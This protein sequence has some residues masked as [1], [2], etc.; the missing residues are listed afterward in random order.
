MTKSYLHVVFKPSII[1]IAIK[2]MLELSLHA[3]THSRHIAVHPCRP[4]LYRASHR[5]R[6]EIQP[7]LTQWSIV[8]ASRLSFV[9]QT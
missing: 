6:K 8:L 7:I 2:Q 5:A 9:F 4:R 3:E 1:A